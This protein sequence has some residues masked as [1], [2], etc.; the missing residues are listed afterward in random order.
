LPKEKEGFE[1]AMKY[2]VKNVKRNT[3]Q[4]VYAAKET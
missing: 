1:M 4:S 3:M 2:L